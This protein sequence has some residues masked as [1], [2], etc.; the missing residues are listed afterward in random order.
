V[1]GGNRQTQ[2]LSNGEERKRGRRK[3]E[4]REGERDTAV[5]PAH[6]FLHSPIQMEVKQQT[7]VHLLRRA[8]RGT[9]ELLTEWTVG[10]Q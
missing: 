3:R 6:S 8:L 1:E 2:Q 10:I 7:Q 5:Y 4:G 9:A